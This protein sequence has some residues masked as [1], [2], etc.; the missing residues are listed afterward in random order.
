MKIIEGDIIH[1]RETFICHQTNCVSNR[2]AGLAA[3]LFKHFPWADCYSERIDS[4]DNDEPGHIDVRGDGAGERY[5][6]NMM[7]Q[8]YP[9][10]TRFQDAREHYFKLCLIELISL[11]RGHRNSTFAFP[12]GIGCGLAGGDWKV[13]EE[14]LQEFADKIG[15]DRVVIYKK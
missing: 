3:Y 15:E 9:G 14:M 7:A 2:G 13:Y 5:V 12:W 6:V 4:V 8:F 10:K 1:A 11:S